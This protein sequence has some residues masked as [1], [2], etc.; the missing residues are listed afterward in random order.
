MSELHI[1]NDVINTGVVE[2]AISYQIKEKVTEKQIPLTWRVNTLCNML[3][4]KKDPVKKRP[5]A[6]YELVQTL[7]QRLHDFTEGVLHTLDTKQIKALIGGDGSVLLPYVAIP[8]TTTVNE[9]TKEEETEAYN[10]LLTKLT[11]DQL[12]KF[13]EMVTQFDKEAYQTEQTKKLEKKAKKSTKSSGYV[14]VTNEEAAAIVATYYANLASGSSTCTPE[15]FRK[16]GVSNPTQSFNRLLFSHIF[17]EDC[18]HINSM[19]TSAYDYWKKNNTTDVTADYEKNKTIREAY[20]IANPDY[21]TKLKENLSTKG[22][23]AAVRK[24]VD[25]TQEA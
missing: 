25:K 13:L 17:P 6:K 22:Y 20:C 5:L 12:W 3:G 9:L 4:I 18:T 10:N 19:A 16:S 14:E 21:L 1:T 8:T 11:V 24:K 23:T 15:C 2:A 7:K